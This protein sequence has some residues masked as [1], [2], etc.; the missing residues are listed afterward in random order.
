MNS[1]CK[2][3]NFHVPH[4]CVLDK[5]I[6]GNHDIP[7]HTHCSYTRLPGLYTQYNLAWKENTCF[8]CS[9]QVN[10]KTNVCSVYFTDYNKITLFKSLDEAIQP[11]LARLETL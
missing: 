6:L 8:R 4:Q 1:Q 7:L 3:I 2:S 5:N 11:L 9:F 10:S